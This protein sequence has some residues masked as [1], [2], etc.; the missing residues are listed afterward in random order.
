MPDPVTFG[1]LLVVAITP[2][3]LI[4]RRH[5]DVAND[6]LASRKRLAQELHDACVQ[7]SDLLEHTFDTA[8]TQLAKEG[9]SSARSVIERQQEDFNTLDYGS[10]AFESTVLKGLR[11]DPRFCGFADACERFYDQAI[12][13][14][15]IAYAAFED[16]GGSVNMQK[17][18]IGRVARV[19]KRHIEGAL[20]EVRSE[21]GGINSIEQS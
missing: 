2:M 3:Y 14:K 15:A 10:L 6:N 17:D 7:W 9:A 20:E 1:T 4:L 18:G 21:F 11:V 19:W 12:S 16:D 5:F 13:V 8:V